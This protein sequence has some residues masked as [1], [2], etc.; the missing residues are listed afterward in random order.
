[1]SIDLGIAKQKLLALKEE[2]ETRI[3]KIKYDIQHPQDELNKDW[4]DQA[5]SIR[6]NDTRQLLSAEAQQNLI[7]VQDAL[8]HIENGT[9]GECE[10]CGEEI[11]EQRMQ[12]VPYATLCMEHAE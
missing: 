9:Y 2:Y 5:I 11:Q 8:S 7:Y 12:A 6:Q 1:M 10:V 3:D 4:E